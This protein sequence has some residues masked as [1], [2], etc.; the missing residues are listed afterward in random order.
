[1][2]AFGLLGILAPALDLKAFIELRGGKGLLRI[3]PPIEQRQSD[4][5]GAAGGRCH[6]QGGQR[7][8]LLLSHGRCKGAEARSRLASRDNPAGNQKRRVVA[9]HRPVDQR[10]PCGVL[11]GCDDFVRKP[12]ELDD[13]EALIRTYLES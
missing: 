10:L 3:D 9:Q 12:F 4:D 8:V 7:E 6:M 5:Q 13:L 11:A 1:M 2:A